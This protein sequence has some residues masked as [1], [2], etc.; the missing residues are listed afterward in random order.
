M[1]P[2][3]SAPLFETNFCV[4]D[5]QIVLAYLAL[6]VAIGMMVNRHVHS[7]ADY[8][9]GGRCAGASLSIA[10]FIGTG[11]GLVTLMYASLEGFKN[12]FSYL[13]LPVLGLFATVVLGATGWVIAPLRRLKLTT[14]P[15]YF[16]HR[17]NRR[18]RVVAGFICALACWRH[19]CRPST[20]R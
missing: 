17:Y 14:I 7:A 10:S 4:I 11:L 13:F 16:Q 6:T 12:G 15:E 1:R 5:L 8:L 19:S 9:V 2:N 18:T 20:R 3:E